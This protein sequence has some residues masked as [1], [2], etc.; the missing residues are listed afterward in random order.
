[1]SFVKA[2]LLPE[3][4][5][6]KRPIVSG[7]SMRACAASPARRPS[8][9]SIP[10][11]SGPSGRSAAKIVRD[12]TA[13]NSTIRLAGGRAG[14]AF[15]SARREPG[16]IAPRAPNPVLATIL[17]LFTNAGPWLEKA[18]LSPRASGGKLAADYVAV[19]AA[20][21]FCAQDAVLR[22][23]AWTIHA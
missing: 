22:C 23:A 16:T 7:V 4:D 18:I 10:S 15:G 1:M 3:P 11:A 21:F 20:I 13:S 8:G 17:I 6:P 2:K 19:E 5:G 12:G 9:A 14:T